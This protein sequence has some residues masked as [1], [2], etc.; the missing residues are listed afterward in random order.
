MTDL[1]FAGFFGGGH[2]VVV[3]EVLGF[4][5]FFGLDMLGF[6]GREEGVLFW[7]FFPEMRHQG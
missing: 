4:L 6:G 3:F 1:W 5:W 2:V 7:V